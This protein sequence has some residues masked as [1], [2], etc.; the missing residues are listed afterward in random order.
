M[1]KK[2]KILIIV[3]LL[4]ISYS[5]FQISREKAYV[6]LEQMV[7]NS[8]NTYEDSNRRIDLL[9]A[10]DIESTKGNLMELS[11]SSGASFTIAF[12]DNIED[13]KVEHYWYLQDDK[14]LSKNIGLNKSLDVK[15]FNDLENP[16]TNHAEDEYYFELPLDT[17]NYEIYPFHLYDKSNLSVDII[18]F[19]DSEQKIDEFVSGLEERGIVYRDFDFGYQAPSFLQT[20]RFTIFQNP[21]SPLTFGLFLIAI[22]AVLYQDRRN[23]SIKMVNGYS[24]TRYI[25]EN[26]KNLLSLQIIILIGSFLILYFFTYY[27]NFKY[28][29]PILMYYLLIA[30]VISLVSIT[31]LAITVYSFTDIGQTTYVQGV[32]PKAFTP[33]MI[34]FS[35]FAIGLLICLSLIP[36]V[37]EIIHT[38]SIYRSMSKQMDKYSDTYII[39]AS[40][41]YSST[42]MEKFD[43]IID[44]LEDF[45]NLIYQS[46]FDGGQA[47]E[48]GKVVKVNDN[49]M[50]MHPLL[51][52]DKK[53]IDLNKTNVVY[54]KVHNIE[55]VERLKPF[56]G[57]LCESEE[58]CFDIE[59]VILDEDAELKMYNIDP[60]VDNEE[61]SKDFILVLQNKDFFISE[62]FF[63]FENNDQIEEVRNALKGVVDIES[64][65]FIKVTDRWERGIDI[66]KDVILR[67]TV[68]F[69]NYLILIVILSL[70]YYQIKFDK[71][72]R[73]FSI[74]WVNGIS[75]FKHFYI[76]YLYQIILSGIMI[77]LV[78]TTFHPEFSM[79]L[80][81][82]I[83]F[84][85][86]FIDTISLVI[87]RH[88]FYSQVQKNIK[89]QM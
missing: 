72:K 32:K 27:F 3:L 83:F 79:K 73:E 20:I 60:L 4:L 14:Y 25:L 17:Y 37:D 15:E 86:I 6:N 48:T 66:Y 24:K 64:V 8:Y 16:I 42:I 52:E 69:I 5:I 68:T 62:L 33:L 44:E 47:E 31:F 30:L 18:I 35:K 77:M 54:T 11:D 87:F 9:G 34:G 59:V 58:D 41:S 84:I 38:S 85:F 50:K 70:I 56:P 81:F 49:Y 88:Q 75:K 1:N 53:P 12:A 89:E 39:D 40:G 63:I 46:H 23:L 61:I 26:I 45:D 36:L 57:F 21:L 43:E 7:F 55:G 78:K 82:L 2:W 19:A 76:D 71:V 51:T 65:D 74:Y 80:T 13:G 28:F 67:N 29:F 22:F 10:D